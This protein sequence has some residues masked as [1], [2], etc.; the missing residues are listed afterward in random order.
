AHLGYN[1]RAEHIFYEMIAK[2]ESIVDSYYQL[3]Q[4][5]ITLNEANKAFLFGMNY[6]ILADDDDY[7]EELEEMFEVTYNSEEKIEVEC[8]LFAV[9]LI[10]QYLFSQGRL[11]EARNFVLNQN[12]AIQ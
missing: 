5:N 9:Q 10:F 8:Q 2:Q 4:L 6:V 11:P 7:Q 12:E 1:N 3:S